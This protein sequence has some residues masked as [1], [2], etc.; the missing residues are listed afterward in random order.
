MAQE[1]ITSQPYEQFMSV[2]EAS[3]LLRT[4]R[5]TLYCYLSSKRLPAKLYRRIGRKVLFLKDELI[6]W[7]KDGAELEG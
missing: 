2:L 4:T 7:V 5:K 3:S 1:N 6:Q